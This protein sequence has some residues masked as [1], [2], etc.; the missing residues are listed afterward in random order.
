[1]NSIEMDLKRAFFSKKFLVGVLLQTFALCPAGTDSDLFQISVPVLCTLPYASA[2]LSDYESGF[3]KLY[4]MRTERAYYIIGKI[5]ACGVSGGSVTALGGVLYVLFVGN[6]DAEAV[7]FLLFFLSG[8]LWAVLA[9]VLAVWSNSRYIACGGGFVI[10]YL[11]IILYERYFEELYCLYP[12]EWLKP[13]HVWI[14][15]ENGIVLLTG[16]VTLILALLYAKMLWRCM[17]CL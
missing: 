7:S 9:A 2:W 10:C 11:L 4:L 6:E 3:L 14:F 15:G 16:G 17:E 12:V 1:M 5:L 13:E 8:M